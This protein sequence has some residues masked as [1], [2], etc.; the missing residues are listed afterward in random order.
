MEHSVEIGVIIAISLL[1]VAVLSSIFLSKVRFPY[2]IG[3]VVIGGLWAFA[4]QHIE[5]LTPMSNLSLSPDLILFLILPTLIFD[6]AININIQL[7]YKNLVPILLLAF[8]GIVISTVVIGTSLPLISTLTLGGALLFGALI[9]ATDPVAVIALFNEIKAPKRL[10]TLIDGESIF[11]DATAIVLFTIILEKQIQNYQ[12]VV[13]NFWPGLLSFVVVLFGGILIGGIVGLLGSLM[14]RIRRGDMIL[15]FTVTLITAYISFILAD[16][17]AVSGVISTLTAGLVF[18]AT[19][20]Y[21]IR[22]RNRD[23]LHH[24]WEFFSFI[25]NSF[26]FLLLGFT[27]YSI[28]KTTQSIRHFIWIILLAIPIIIIARVC[29]IYIL[30]PLYNK[31][32]GK[33]Q[34]ISRSYQAILHSDLFCL[35]SCFRVQPSSSSWACWV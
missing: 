19:S 9:S 21:T 4:A 15:Q 30:V 7:L 25:A 18:T 31:F 20:D 33:K 14:L 34:R 10:L 35:P 16:R 22:R 23:S 11:N 29:V 8:I 3:L 12:D 27:E 5:I 1:T 17:L 6:A 13:T 26:V 28:F 2:T 32:A 24:F